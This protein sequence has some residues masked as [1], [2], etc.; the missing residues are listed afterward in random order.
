MTSGAQPYHFKAFV[1]YS[2]RDAKWGVWLHRA[3][4]NYRIP[5]H[6]GDSDTGGPRRLRPVFRDREELATSS[7]L[8]S[9]IREALQNS[10]YLVVV[11]SPNAARSR[12]VNEEIRAFIELGR[13]KRILCFAIDRLEDSLPPALAD[14]EPLAADPRPEADGRRGAKLKLIAGLLNVRY[15]ELARRD[16]ARR[17]RRLAATA[18]TALAG[19]LLT[20]GLALYANLQR[21]EAIEQ[22]ARATQEAATLE[23]VVDFMTGVFDAGNPEIAMGRDPRAS[24]LLRTGVESIDESLDE[25]PAV[26]ARLLKTLGQVHWRRNEIETAQKLIQ[27]ALDIR[28]SMGETSGDDYLGDIML[29]ALIKHESGE[30]EAA[31]RL[32]EEALAGKIA[33]HGPEHRDVLI[34]KANLG[35][36]YDDTGRYQEALEVARDVL[37]RKKRALGETDPSTL[38]SVLNLGSLLGSMRRYDEALEVF[39]EA[40]E[41]AAVE[42]GEDH[43][44]TLSIDE[45]RAVVLSYL[46]RNEEQESLRL[47]VLERKTRV[48]GDEHIETLLSRRNL[49]LLYAETERLPLAEELLDGVV[50]I[51]SRKFGEQDAE[52]LRSRTQLASLWSEQGRHEEVAAAMPDIVQGLAERFG[53]DHPY[54]VDALVEWGVALTALGRR[55]QARDV[56]ERALAANVALYGA[57]D[58]GG[59]E[60]RELLDSARD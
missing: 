59:G 43:P 57:E 30:F 49:A 19:M 32:Y 21:Q 40:R 38:T 14:L 5:S 39:E 16:D 15:D 58:V 42:M 48:Y 23:R 52:T 55:T 53:D 27:R 31:E 41:R 47:D 10:E 18:F 51:A 45:N 35:T 56:L 4:E 13:A 17:H 37:E 54:V 22:R 36:L 46:G 28:Q 3:I 11:C 25:D 44:M 1:S 26:K 50:A 9:S 60:I 12:W 2:H 7:D 24:E 20:S 33:L 34:A 29:L 8:G 6:I